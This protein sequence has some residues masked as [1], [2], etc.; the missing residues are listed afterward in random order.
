[1]VGVV[2]VVVVGVVGSGE[3]VVVELLGR[4]F[5]GTVPI[6]G[7]DRACDRGATVRVEAQPAK[8]TAPHITAQ[9]RKDLPRGC[10]GRV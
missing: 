8:S 4:R 1:M 2:V 5:L 7:R 10:H 3:V 9:H 6:M